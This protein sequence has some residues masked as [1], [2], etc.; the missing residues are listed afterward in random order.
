MK[1][2]VNLTC[3]VCPAGCRMTAELDENGKVVSITG[4]TCPR[5]KTYG[6]SEITNPVRTLTSIV[7]IEGAKNH[8]VMLPVKTSKPIPKGTLF[9]AMDK[10]RRITVKAPVEMG[11]VLEKDFI[12]EG[13]DL[14]AC[15]TVL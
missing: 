14:I 11:D 4:N 5:G 13:T 9:E 12:A 3:V 2:I 7:K 8:T 15:K 10:I 1:Q 6:E